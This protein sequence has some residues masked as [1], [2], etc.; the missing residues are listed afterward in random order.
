MQNNFPITPA[1]LPIDNFDN[2]KQQYFNLK[3]V[4]NY[5]RNW[6]FTGGYSYMK[7]SHNDIATDGYQYV[8]PIVRDSGAGGIV[9]ATGTAIR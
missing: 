6:S 5:N 8:L 3:G 2:S 7:Y 9:P 1:A 4:W